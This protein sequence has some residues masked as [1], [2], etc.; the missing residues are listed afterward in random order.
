MRIT[1]KAVPVALLVSMIWLAPGCGGDDDS[2]GGAAGS[3]GTNV[4]GGSTGE[5]GEDSGGTGATGTG[6]GGASEGGNPGTGQGGASEGGNPGTGQGGASEGG[7]PGTGGDDGAGG[8][9]PETL[10]CLGDPLLETAPDNVVI[11]GLVTTLGNVIINGALVEGRA[12]SDDGLLGDDTSALNGS[13]ELTVPT[14]GAPLDAYL[15]VSADGSVDSYVYPPIP[16]V[17]DDELDVP[18]ITSALRTG[19]ADEANV[20]LEADTG[21]LYVFV[22]DCNG[23]PVEGATVTTNPPGDLSYTAGFVPAPDAT[24]TDGSGAAYIFNLPPGNVEVDATID[25]YSLREHTI[26]VRANV[27]TITSVIP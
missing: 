3:A 14:G 10:D 6:Q 15:Y 23:D 5:G 21:V 8:A 25:G 18:L 2:D 19:I 4:R 1:L 20:T 16:F 24:S 17:D 7:N 9:L 13:Y 26:D 11:S 27:M 22:R 12:A